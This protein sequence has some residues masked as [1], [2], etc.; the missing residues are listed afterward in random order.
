[1]W[2]YNKMQREVKPT[3]KDKSLIYIPKGVE[4][5]KLALHDVQVNNNVKVIKCTGYDCKFCK[6]ARL[7]DVVSL[8]RAKR[9]VLDTTD[10]VMIP[11]FELCKSTDRGKVVKVANLEFFIIREF[12]Y[13]NL[14]KGLR[15]NNNKLKG[16]IKVCVDFNNCKHL[17]VSKLAGE[18][19]FAVPM[20]WLPVKFS[21]TELD[22]VY[23][24]KFERELA[25]ALNTI[26]QGKLNNKALEVALKGIQEEIAA[27]IIQG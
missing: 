11:Y 3:T 5:T 7:Q 4:V 27:T 21:R 9:Y 1:M 8:Q 23:A 18:N 6:L 12:T 14:W 25:N 17:G 15:D 19:G 22:R 2:R 20:E 26:N 24:E 13:K 16:G 10:Y